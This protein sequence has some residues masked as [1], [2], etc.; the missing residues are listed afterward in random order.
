M[1]GAS[2]GAKKRHRDTRTF[3]E[4]KLKQ[5]S[6]NIKCSLNAALIHALRVTTHRVVDQNSNSIVRGVA[7]PPLLCCVGRRAWF[8]S[9]SIHKFGDEFIPSGL[10]AEGALFIATTGTNT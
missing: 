1:K 9:P 7:C 8:L 3:V 2:H 6:H 5:D 4:A 10:S